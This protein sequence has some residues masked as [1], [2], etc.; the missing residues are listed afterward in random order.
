M[1]KTLHI[2]NPNSISPT[3]CKSCA[4]LAISAWTE[5]FPFDVFALFPKNSA[6]KPSLRVLGLV[7]LFTFNIVRAEV[8]VWEKVE[9]TFH[10]RNQYANPYTNVEMWV[11]LKGPGFDKRCYGFWD[12]DNIFRVRVLATQPGQWSWQSG[13]NQKD[14]GLNHHQGGF[15]AVAWSEAE[16]EPVP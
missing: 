12:G 2:K 7:L 9:L 10:A 3:A 15:N 13:S 11:D 16:K 6:M 8:H 4:S 1:G 5:C 14:A